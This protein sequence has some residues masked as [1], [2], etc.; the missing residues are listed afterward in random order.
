MTRGP[1]F[2]FGDLVD[3]RSSV[4]GHLMHGEPTPAVPRLDV[5]AGSFTTVHTSDG[6]AVAFTDAPREEIVQRIVG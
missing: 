3:S 1:T 4:L 5:G 2:Q 6:E